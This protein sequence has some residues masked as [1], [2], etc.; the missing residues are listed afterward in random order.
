MKTVPDNLR[1]RLGRSDLRVSPV[2]LG[3]MS[4]SGVYGAADDSQSEALIEHFVQLAPDDWR[5]QLYQGR[6]G[7]F[8]FSSLPVRIARAD[9]F[10]GVDIPDRL[11]NPDAIA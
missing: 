4:L 2:G 10:A 5:H 6:D 8:A 11:T 9:I 1:R 3:C 7:D